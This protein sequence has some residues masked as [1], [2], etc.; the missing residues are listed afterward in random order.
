METFTP[1]EIKRVYKEYATQQRTSAEI[2]EKVWCE[3]AEP[4]SLADWLEDGIFTCCPESDSDISI[5]DIVMR[6]RENPYKAIDDF[7]KAAVA[8]GFPLC[9]VA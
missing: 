4:A 5:Y 8:A 7:V 1:Q 9:L 6:G 2:A 3:R